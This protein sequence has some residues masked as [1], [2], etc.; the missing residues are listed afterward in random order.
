MI[1]AEWG[2][3]GTPEF[4]SRWHKSILDGAIR[5]IRFCEEY[6]KNKC[7]TCKYIFD[8]GEI[9]FEDTIRITS[10]SFIKGNPKHP[11]RCVKCRK[12]NFIFEDA[13]DGEELSLIWDKDMPQEVFNQEILRGLHVEDDTN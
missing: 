6:Q 4:M 3:F 13:G 12:T 8:V 11:I 9:F 1:N 10:A 7:L 5:E 2:E